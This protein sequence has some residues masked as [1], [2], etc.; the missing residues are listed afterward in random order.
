M[1]SYYR[2]NPQLDRSKAL[3][4]LQR[5]EQTLCEFPASGATF[6]DLDGVREYVIQGTAF[7]LLYTVARD[8]IW[9]IDVHDQRGLRSAD[10]LRLFNREL[11]LRYGV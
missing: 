2:N 3:A 5:A 6:Q 4:A 9:I 7:S 10:A 1:R 8:T 11:R